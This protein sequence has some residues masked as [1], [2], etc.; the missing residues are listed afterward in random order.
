MRQG[1]VSSAKKVYPLQCALQRPSVLRRCSAHY[2]AFASTLSNAP[3]MVALLDAA[4][5]GKDAAIPQRRG[6]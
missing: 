5:C 2:K 6:S 4:R 3:Y 1:K